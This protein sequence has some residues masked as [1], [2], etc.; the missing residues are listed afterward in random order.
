M[1][2]LSTESVL[3]FTYVFSMKRP[4]KDFGPELTGRF[5]IR[6]SSLYRRSLHGCTSKFW[7]AIKTR[8]DM[9]QTRNQK[10]VGYKCMYI[11]AGAAVH[12]YFCYEF[13]GESGRV[14]SRRV[15]RA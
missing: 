12:G 4:Y 13:L 1:Y 14:S 15:S 6:E 8:K 10:T 5:P 9:G 2:Y 7:D 11:N 3:H